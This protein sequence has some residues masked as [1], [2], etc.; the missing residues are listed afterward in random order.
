[1]RYQLRHAAGTYWLLDT[2][3]EGIPYRKPLV[4][5]EVGA[6]IWKMMEQGCC[7]EQIE[8]ALCQEYQISKE[9]VGQDVEQF[10]AQLAEYG[11]E[12]TAENKLSDDSRKE[13]I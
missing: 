12:V 1:M 10:Q 7:R 13:G 6:K 11:I 8:N 9:L 3:Q 5:N 4:M 2:W